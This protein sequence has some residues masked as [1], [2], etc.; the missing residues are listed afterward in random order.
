MVKSGINNVIFDLGG[1]ILDLDFEASYREFSRLSG[2]NPEEVITR[3]R[4]LM[5]FEDYE[6]GAISSSVFRDKINNLLEMSATDEEIDGAWCA[7]LGNMPRERLELLKKLQDVYRTF[8]LSNT[9]EIHA[10]TFDN[11]VGSSLG[12][13]AL[14]SEHFEKVYFS[15]EMNLRKPDAEIYRAVLDDLGIKPEETLFIDDTQANIQAADNLGIHT[16]H[17]T[18][19]RQLIPYF[20]GSR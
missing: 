8:V 11:I 19:A 6:T 17:L 16:L 1:V 7:M 3:T 12:N 9:N 14:F 10:R 20:D 18:D 13:S 5:F 15:H 2:L 4:G